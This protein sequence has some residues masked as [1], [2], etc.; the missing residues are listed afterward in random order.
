MG[1]TVYELK[2]HLNHQQYEWPLSLVRYPLRLQPGEAHPG[3]LALRDGDGLRVP[4]QL[5]GAELSDGFVISG[6]IAFLADLPRG[7]TRRYELHYGA[8]PESVADEEEHEGVS[9]SRGMAVRE[10]GDGI[11]FGNGLIEVAVPRA[12]S[13]LAGAGGDRTAPG[14]AKAANSAK[15]AELRTTRPDSGEISPE[16][17]E[18]QEVFGLYLTNGGKLATA[19]LASGHRLCAVQSE[20][21]SSG[22]VLHE[23]RITFL[24]ENDARYALTIRL[25]AEMPF[26][27]LEEQM[28]GAAGSRLDIEW[29]GLQPTRRYTKSRGDEAI[30]AYLGERGKLPF[31]I[32][33]YDNFLSWHTGRSAAFVD[34]GERLAVGLFHGDPMKWDDGEYA[35]WRSSDTLA[36]SFRYGQAGLEE[37]EEGRLIWSYPLASGVRATKVAVYDP[38]R[39]RAALSTAALRVPATGDG[40]PL[41][42]ELALW[43]SFL[44]LDKVKD[45]VLDWEEPQEQYPRLFDP[46]QLPKAGH[47]WYFELHEA[48][49]P[50][51]MEEIVDKLSFNFN[52]VEGTAP[53]SSREFAFWTPV[54]DLSARDMTR[55]QFRRFKAASALMA[56]VREDEY[57]API[58]TMLSGHPNFLVDYKAVLGYMSALFPHH[59]HAGRWMAHYEK[60]MALNLKYHTRPDVAPWNA[61]GGRWTENLGCYVW[62]ALVPMVRSAW[63]LRKTYGES[64]LLYPN[65]AKLGGWLLRSLSAP[66]AGGRSYPPQGAHSGVH[67]DPLPPSYAIRVLGEMMMD[68]DPLLAEQLLAV[69][70]AEAPGFESGDHCDVWRIMLQGEY[71]SNPGTPPQL[72]SAKFN[73]YG[74]VLRS[75]IGTSGEMSVHLQQIDEGPNYRWGRSGDGGNGVIYYYADGKRYS[76]N[77]PEDVGDDNMGT[78]EGS[79]TFAVLDGHE[80]KSIGRNELTGALHDFGYAQ[81]AELAAGPAARPHYRSRSVLMSGND[82]IVIYDEVADMRVRG[83]FSWFSHRDDPFPAIY[84]LKPGASPSQVTLAGPIDGPQVPAG[85]YKIN[86]KAHGYPNGSVG[87]YYDGFGDFLTVVTHRGEWQPQIKGVKATRY[88]AVVAMVGREDHIFRS[89]TRIR[90][91]GDDLA[92]DGYAGI[93]RRYGRGHVE[94]ALFR[95]RFIAAEGIKA[96]ILPGEAPDR[97]SATDAAMATAGVSAE[98]LDCG[99]TEAT[100]KAESSTLAEA[101]DGSTI[102]GAPGPS[103]DSPYGGSLQGAGAFEFATVSGLLSGS[104]SSAI[105]LVVRLELPNS[106]VTGQHKLYV[107]GKAHEAKAAVGNEAGESV[108]VL[109]F[110]LPAGRMEWQWTDGDA[111]PGRFGAIRM[112][113][114]SPHE[115]ELEWDS[116]EGADRYELAVSKD[117]CRSWKT[118]A[119]D[120]RGQ[121][122][123]LEGLIAGTKLHVR[124]RAC[125][126]QATGDWSEPYPIYPSAQPP[127]APQGL[128]LRRRDGAVEATWGMV[129]GAQRYRLYRRKAEGG[130]SV[131]LY[132]GTERRFLDDS[133]TADEMDW[134]YSVASVNGNGQGP[135]SRDRDTV[136]GGL[137][138]WDPK[139]DETFRRYIRSHE[140][141]HNGFDYW[142]NV[143]KGSLPPYPQS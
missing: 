141:G 10:D 123:R 30:D 74:H 22:A 52:Q 102:A 61:E 31:R 48:P 78:G 115:A 116:A 39:K 58:H 54:F 9:E 90:H 128:R 122:Y 64:T 11:R 104:S 14:W 21:I 97:G 77:R 93:V 109:E 41:I 80:Y 88:G 76:Y 120:I 84:Q 35:L 103:V 89:A 131:L 91:N 86:R 126:G 105:P 25:A 33:P 8:A 101:V 59:P 66:L 18:S 138:D 92:F 12:G 98:A 7:G 42:D 71:L 65:L 107:D 72:K 125:R 60:A 99:V 134:V 81:F 132:E 143:K 121:H 87:R 36:I 29:T 23:H 67:N 32:M 4:V 95:G 137:I 68:Y 44:P 124:V 43:H 129:L 70:P 16:A 53:V 5:V 108:T 113:L 130:E 24:W 111:V 127:A 133:I 3:S 55:E 110:V 75:A 6:E 40:L 2:D 26:V 19:R 69:C 142:E 135:R 47:M 139:P 94:A 63:C 62:A 13:A 106:R 56:Y 50:E 119:D 136:P 1:A 73:G 51:D 140:Y 28:E 46:E 79:T 83:R 17:V 37:G 49:R 85:Q 27:E 118:A 15:T 114:A 117:G 38:D 100:A 45:W 20:C 96:T 57:V 34:E 82:Y 112:S